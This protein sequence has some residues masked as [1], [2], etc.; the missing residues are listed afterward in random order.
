[1]SY[2]EKA[3]SS[4]EKLNTVETFFLLITVR[5]LDQ[6]QLRFCWGFWNKSFHGNRCREFLFKFYNNILGLNVRVANFVGGHDAECTFCCVGLEPRPIPAESFIH[7]FFDCPNSEKY[8]LA[9][10]T[11]FFP[12]IARY[13]REQRLYFWFTGGL[14]YQNSLVYN[15]FIMFVV[16]NTNYWIWKCKLMKEILPES[17]LVKDLIFNIRKGLKLSRKMRESRAELNVYIC[18]HDFFRNGGRGDP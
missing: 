15:E 5:K 11:T 18:R 14:Q 12:E 10:E 7:V 8:R 13:S 16:A 17:I 9:V 6:K 1:L 4:I 3:K 2:E